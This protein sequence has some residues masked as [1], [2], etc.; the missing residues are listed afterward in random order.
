MI[1]LTK[2]FKPKHIIDIENSPFIKPSKSYYFGKIKYGTP[3]F[4]PMNFNPTILSFRKLKLTP[5]EDLDKLSNDWQRKAKK[6]SNIPQV[7]RKWDKIFQIFGYHF[8][9]ALG[10]PI[11]FE[12]TELGWKDKFNTPRYEWAPAFS[13]YFFYWQFY[14]YFDIKEKSGFTDKYWEMYL[15]WKYYSDEDLEKARKTWA[16]TSGGKSTWDETYIDI[17]NKRD[18]LLKKLGL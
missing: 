11:K 16:W 8:W 18:K 7:R 10:W 5:Q 6:Y 14:V 13:L 2:I 9:I 1:H 17:Q 12:K 15:W 4:I 3:Y